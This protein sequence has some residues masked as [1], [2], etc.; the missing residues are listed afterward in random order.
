[1]KALATFWSPMLLL[2][3]RLRRYVKLFDA[4]GAAMAW[5]NV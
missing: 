4:A 3:R 5:L 1:M 2:K